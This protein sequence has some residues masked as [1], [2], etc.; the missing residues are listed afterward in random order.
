MQAAD[1]FFR[2]QQLIA[3]TAKI[4]GCIVLGEPIAWGTSNWVPST[5]RGRI[6]E[7]IL[8]AGRIQRFEAKSGRV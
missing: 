2:W 1:E 7:F 6:G 8:R 4:L 5:T 3:Q